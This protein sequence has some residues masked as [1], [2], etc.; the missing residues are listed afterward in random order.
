MVP[1]DIEMGADKS[2]GGKSIKNIES[3]EIH[4]RSARKNNDITHK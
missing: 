3:D 4:V 1:Y 2:W